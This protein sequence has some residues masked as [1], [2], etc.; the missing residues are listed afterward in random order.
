MLIKKT[1]KKP[2]HGVAVK[3]TYGAGGK[4]WNLSE[5]EQEGGS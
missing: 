2:V 1:V 3:V 4:W 5:V